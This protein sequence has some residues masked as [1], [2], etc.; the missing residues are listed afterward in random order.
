[1]SAG[2]PEWYLGSC[3]NI[4]KEKQDAYIQSDT[5]PGGRDDPGGCCDDNRYLRP[6]YAEPAGYRHLEWV[7]IGS[8]KAFGIMSRK[9]FDLNG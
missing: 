8:V 5:V 9:L 6:A 7:A 4:K 1:M 2:I 3:H